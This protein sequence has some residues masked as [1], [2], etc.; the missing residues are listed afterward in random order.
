[1]PGT[2]EPTEVCEGYRFTLT[3]VPPGTTGGFNGFEQA[4]TFA[5]TAQQQGQ[6]P[7]VVQACLARLRTG[8]TAIPPDPSGDQLVEYARQLK[9][10]LRELIEAGDIRSCLLGRRLSDIVI[11]SADDQEAS[12]K[13]QAAIAAMLQIAIDLFREC[14]CSALLPPCG[15]G[16][17]R[18]LR[19]ARGRAVRSS[20]LRVLDICNWSARKTVITMP[21]L[22]Y[23]F[24]WLPDLR[25]RA[26][27]PRTAV[28]QQQGGPRVRG[29][30]QAPGPRERLP[31]QAGA[32]RAGCHPLRGGGSD[33]RAH[34]RAG[35]GRSD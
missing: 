9:A 16:L 24:G 21:A 17:C 1:M 30:R 2:C 33:R 20:D 12:G 5:A 11:P 26:S 31:T 32:A 28:L 14:I 7:A 18:R 3:K 29:E 19:A 22:S 6:L 35:R 10:D 8:L 23:W 15:V 4:G 13:A 25:R 27:K 34:R